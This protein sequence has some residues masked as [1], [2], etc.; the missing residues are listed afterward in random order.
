MGAGRGKTRRASAVLA[1]PTP[2]MRSEQVLC[3]PDEWDAFV[4]NVRL[5]KDNLHRYYL[6]EEP[7]QVTHEDYAKILTELFADA[8]QVGA[9]VLPEGYNAESFQLAV[10][11]DEYTAQMKAELSLKSQPSRKEFI[12]YFSH[13]ISPRA[14]LSDSAIK[15]VLQQIAQNAQKL[16]SEANIA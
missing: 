8:V 11:H 14:T 1:N 13:Y 6:G 5:R 3:R 10:I 7:L 4:S 15:Y 9:I 2:E 12:Y 16:H